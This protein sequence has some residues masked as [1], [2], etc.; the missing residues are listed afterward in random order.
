MSVGGSHSKI[1]GDVCILCFQG[2]IS[3]EKIK[4]C[5][6]FTCENLLNRKI[7]IELN[8]VKQ[9]NEK[10]DFMGESFQDV[11]IYNHCKFD[12]ISLNRMKCKNLFIVEC[13]L[14][15]KLIL[16][17]AVIEENLVVTESKIKDINCQNLHVGNTFSFYKMKFNCINFDG[18]FCAKAS[19]FDIFGFGGK[20]LNKNNFETRN[21]VRFIKYIF[22]ENKNIIEANKYFCIEQEMYMDSFQGINRIWNK[23]FIMVFLSKHISRFGTDWVLPLLWMNIALMVFALIY[24]DMLS[25]YEGMLPIIANIGD[26]TTTISLLALLLYAFCM[27]LLYIVRVKHWGYSVLFGLSVIAYIVGLLMLA[28]MHTLVNDAADLV[29]PFNIFKPT[30]GYFQC[31]VLFGMF[32][33]FVYFVLWYQFI[34]SLWQNTRR[35]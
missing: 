15:K 14:D 24:N 31:H 32:V 5:I 10:L 1:D 4:E 6:N 22:E 28:G 3:I 18:M 7:S 29:N 9:N 33:K 30:K 25:F 11:R 17:D 34:I 19:I 20:V 35:H 13:N 23:D 21:S 12:N 27:Y 8:G 2:N 26:F 16:K